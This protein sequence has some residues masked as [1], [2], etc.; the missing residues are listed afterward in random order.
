MQHAQPVG[1]VDRFGNGTHQRRGIARGQSLEARDA[2][3]EGFAE[4]QLHRVVEQAFLLADRVHADDVGVVQPRGVPGLALEAG[5][6][7]R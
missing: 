6:E 3:V 5:D 2:L 4:D 7:L 1:V